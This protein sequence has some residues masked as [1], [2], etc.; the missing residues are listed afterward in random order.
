MIHRRAFPAYTP[1]MSE[2]SSELTLTPF[3]FQNAPATTDASANPFKLVVDPA[4]RMRLRKALFDMIENHD[5]QLADYVSNGQLM[6]ESY[7]EY[8][9]IFARS[10]RESMGTVDGVNYLIN[11]CGFQVDPEEINLTPETR[12]T[13]PPTDS[14]Q[15]L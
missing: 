7:K 4:M 1:G 14:E 11:S 9:E 3:E 10:L 12:W 8:I 15:S 2:I 13:K 5:A 6:L